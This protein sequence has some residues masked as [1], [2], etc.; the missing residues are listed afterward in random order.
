MPNLYDITA[1]PLGLSKLANIR[2]TTSYLAK[3]GQG[4]F[5]Q[6]QS[7]NDFERLIKEYGYK[8]LLDPTKAVVFDPTR[9]RQVR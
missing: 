2:N 7:L 6:P 5:D 9:V 1:D 8:G 3:Y 4:R